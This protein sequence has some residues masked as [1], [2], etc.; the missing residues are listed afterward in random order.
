[1]NTFFILHTLYISVL[2][3]LTFLARG[4][5][6]LALRLITK[7]N[8]K[9]KIMK[10][11]LIT[12]ATFASLLTGKMDNNISESITN[13][14]LESATTEVL[15]TTCITGLVKATKYNGEIIPSVQ[16]PTLNIIGVS[17]K[18]SKVITTVNNGERIPMVNL[19]TLNIEA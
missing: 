4:G 7:N 8:L 17:E 3:L 2:Q 10:T 5:T 9:F 13:S 16:L 15:N 11:I 19:P 1:M 18:G 6:Q 14:T 12:L